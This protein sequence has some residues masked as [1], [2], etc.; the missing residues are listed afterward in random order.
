MPKLWSP[1][2]LPRMPYIRTFEPVTST[3]S[4]AWAFH[5]NLSVPLCMAGLGGTYSNLLSL[6]FSWSVTHM[7]AQSLSGSESPIQVPFCALVLAPLHRNSPFRRSS[8]DSP[9]RGTDT[10]G[11]CASYGAGLEGNEGQAA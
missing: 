3:L 4:L 7:P 10:E 2:G 11:L 5:S 9:F 8:L 1:L 6:C